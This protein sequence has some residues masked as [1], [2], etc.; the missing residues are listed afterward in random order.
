MLMLF[1][2]GEFTCLSIFSPFRYTDPYSTPT[3]AGEICISNTF[4]V[5]L[6]HSHSG[7]YPLTSA[8]MSHIVCKRFS[9]HSQ[10]LVGSRDLVFNIA[11][12]WTAGQNYSLDKIILECHQMHVDYEQ[13]DVSFTH[14][15]LTIISIFHCAGD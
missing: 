2:L 4:E 13:T 7:V 5:T 12:V 9:R 10:C 15:T 11:P 6:C 14:F 3:K 8:S 1:W